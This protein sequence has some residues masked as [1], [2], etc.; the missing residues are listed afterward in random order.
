MSLLLSFQQQ[1][2]IKP[3]ASLN[4]EKYD[5]IAREVE[6]NDLL[7]ML[8]IALLQDV[9]DF[10]DKEYNAKLLD[11]DTFVDLFGNTI[12]T[13]GLRYILAYLNYAKYVL[14][15]GIED[16]YA[17]FKQLKNEQTDPLSEGSKRNLIENARNIAATQFEVMKRYLNANL[18]NFPLWYYGLSRSS[19]STRFYGVKKTL[20]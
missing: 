1:Q 8:G 4:A 14:N 7:G 17:G 11:G 10:P 2:A 16:T 13:R 15:S 5:Q 6:D 20:R 3:I 12:K 19:T 9:Q 18:A